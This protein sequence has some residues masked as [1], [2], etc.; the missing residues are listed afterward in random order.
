MNN[1]SLIEEKEAVQRARK[2]FGT[3]LILCLL[4]NACTTLP[5][6]VNKQYLTLSAALT[7][8]RQ[9]NSATDEK[10]VIL[11]RKA[12]SDLHGNPSKTSKK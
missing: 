5:H 3:P 8:E 12:Q 6:Q 4:L 9:L 2:S 1:I 10:A 7:H 11:A